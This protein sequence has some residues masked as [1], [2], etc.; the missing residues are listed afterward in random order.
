MRRHAQGTNP[1]AVNLGASPPVTTKS[2]TEKKKKKQSFVELIVAICSL[3]ARSCEIYYFFFFIIIFIIKMFQS[4]IG[5]IGSL[6][7]YTAFIRLGLIVYD[8]KKYLKINNFFLTIYD[9]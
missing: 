9:W 1:D 4:F 7:M 8:R 2:H 5:A 3:F 6:V